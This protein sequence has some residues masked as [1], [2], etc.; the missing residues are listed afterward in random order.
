M[1]SLGS[2]ICLLLLMPSAWRGL[3]AA[4]RKKD[5]FSHC[6]YF[7]FAGLFSAVANLVASWA[8]LKT[9]V[10]TVTVI[11]STSLFFTMLINSFLR[12]TGEKFNIKLVATGILIVGGISLLVLP[13]NHG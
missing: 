11:G 6:Y 1:N 5:F 12:S 10:S 4:Y 13:G 8:L 9:G 7:I 3:F 2:I